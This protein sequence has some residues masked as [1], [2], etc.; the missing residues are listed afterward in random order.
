MSSCLHEL[1][2]WNCKPK[3]KKKKKKKKENVQQDVQKLIIQ[4][5]RE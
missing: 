3:E 5:R 2:L 1:S 4:T